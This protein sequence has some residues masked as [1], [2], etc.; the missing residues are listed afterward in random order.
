MSK[1]TLIG[2]PSPLPSRTSLINLE[3]TMKG[4]KVE[5]RGTGHWLHYLIWELCEGRKG[6]SESCKIKV[7]KEKRDGGR[8]KIERK[9]SK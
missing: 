6:S 9:K 1:K 5:R 3:K 2:S 8:K 7:R 4:G